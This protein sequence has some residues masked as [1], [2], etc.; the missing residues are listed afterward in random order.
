[1]NSIAIGNQ[2]LPIKDYYCSDNNGYIPR[3]DGKLW[4]YVNVT[5]V[6]NGCC[7]FCINPGR[8]SGTT[9]FDISVFSQITS[10]IKDHVYGISL[11]G[12][13]PMLCPELID[14]ITNTVETIFSREEELDLVTNGIDFHRILDLRHLRRFYS[15]H[16]SRHRLTDGENDLLFGFPTVSWRELKQIISKL[17]DPGMIVLNCLLMTGG[18]DSLEK[19][20]TYLELAASAGVRNVSFIG[21]S[22]CNAFC[23]A[24]YIDPS[25]LF[26]KRNDRFHIWSQYH[27]HTF[28][29][30]MSGSYDAAPGSIRFY[31]RSI[32]TGKPSYTR[33]LVYTAD[34]Q[35]LAGFGGAEISIL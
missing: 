4:L 19:A 29:S 27:D 14:E 1:M 6:C 13:E 32:G 21:M 16:L 25:E 8:K 10:R 35:L 9:P 7:P 31:F 33:Q 30:C 26:S 24:H 20:E 3:Q 2:I 5:D 23:E 12:G 22:N 15:V 11:T 17:D 28:C 34:N 18:I